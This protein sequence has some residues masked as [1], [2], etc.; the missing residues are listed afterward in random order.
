MDITALKQALTPMVSTTLANDI[1]DEFIDLRRDVITGALGGSA[2]GKFVETYAQILQ[3]LHANSYDNKPN[4]DKTLRDAE[5]WGVIDDSLRICGARMAR[6]MYALRSKRNI[7]HKG[8]IDPNAYDHVFLHHGA[9]WLMSELLRLSKYL[10]KEQA[11]QLITQVQTPM[12]DL[13]E[14]MG[15][16]QLVLHN[17]ITAT[18]EMILLLKHHYP[19]SQSLSNLYLSMNRRSKTTVRGVAKKLWRERMADGNGADGYRLT[20]LGYDCANNLIATLNN[21]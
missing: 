14:D 7:V 17:G 15:G 12:T 9:Q 10:T 3:F 16:S 5:S 6:T 18:D 13:V 4:V 21:T 19:A 11:G 20:S 2:G 8:N 1:V